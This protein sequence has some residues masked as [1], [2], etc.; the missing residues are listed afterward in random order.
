MTG[1]ARLQGVKPSDDTG[2]GKTSPV[3]DTIDEQSPEVIPGTVRT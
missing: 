2:S 3:C 1:C